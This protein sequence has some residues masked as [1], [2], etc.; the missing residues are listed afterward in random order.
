MTQPSIASLFSKA[1]GPA[2]APAPALKPKPK[3]PLT[4]IPKPTVPAPPAPT[5]HR[6]PSKNLLGARLQPVS[7]AQLEKKIEALRAKQSDARIVV[8]SLCWR[9]RCGSADAYRVMNE[10]KGAAYDT[11]KEQTV[12]SYYE[13]MGL[14]GEGGVGDAIV[15]ALS[16]DE[17]THVLVVDATPKA[18]LA[19]LAACF[20]AV[21][22]KLAKGRVI[23]VAPP[24]NPLFAEAVAAASVCTAAS[25]LHYT[26]EAHFDA[27]LAYQV[28]PVVEEADGGEV[29]RKKAKKS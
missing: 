7:A 29:P 8:L 11:F 22:L 24:A 15:E 12:L 10:P 26:M 25:M 28:E 17:R 5:A 4:L 23:K 18:E 21:R 2:P 20:G 16:E 19:R 27:K 3:P 9:L 1:P 13:F 14:C 6:K